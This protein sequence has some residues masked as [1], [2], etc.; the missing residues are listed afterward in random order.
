MEIV[1]RNRIGLWNVPFISSAYLIKGDLIN[2]PNEKMRPNFVNKLLD[3]DMAFC[4]NL[5]ENDIFFYISNRA[6]FGHL[7]DAEGFNTEHLNNE[8]W[9]LSRNR[10]DWEARYIHADY[11]KSFEENANLSQPCPDVYWF[12]IITERFA[13]ELVAEMENFGKWSD[14]T[15][16]VS[17]M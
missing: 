3:A 15:N 8:L 6:S 11:H 5:R 14:G 17:E 7:I 12:P 10:W 2:H 9:E 13:D 1:Q 16:N 4:A